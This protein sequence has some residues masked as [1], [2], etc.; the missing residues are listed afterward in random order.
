MKKINLRQL[1]AFRAVMLT[2]S[3]T[4]AAEMLFISQPAVSRLISDLETSIEFPLFQRVKK[5]LIATPEADA[6]FEEVERSFAGLN[7]INIVAREIRDFRSGNLSIAA[8]PALGL[9][10]LPERISQFAAEMPDVSLSLNIRGSQNVSS[11]VAAQRADVGFTESIDFG[12]GIDSELLLTTDLVCILPPD[13]RLKNKKVI[14][15]KD[16]DGETFVGTGNWQLTCKDIDRYFEREKVRRKIR[17]DT[18]LNAT[19]AEF[20]LSGTGVS[21]IDPVTADRY[22]SKGLVVRP[23]VPSIRYSYYVIFPENRPR[24]RL[25]EQFVAQ[26]KQDIKRYKV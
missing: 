26:V 21:V 3:I 5:R 19:V 14:K 2:K 11:L 16:L 18:Q 22:I 15:A 17:I 20:V 23:F 24:S 6:L 7:K 13:H 10:F 8:L 25:A 12:D 1:E 4:R 9:G